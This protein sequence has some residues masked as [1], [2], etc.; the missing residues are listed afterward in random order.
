MTRTSSSLALSAAILSVSLLAAWQSEPADARQD[1]SI[2]LTLGASH[3]IPKTDLTVVFEAVVE[4]SRCPVG[5]NCVWAGNAVVQLRVDSRSAKP[6]S[7]RLHTNDRSAQ[8]VV[9][10][11]VRLRL[12]SLTPEP[13]ADGPPKTED[14]RLTLSIRI[15]REYALPH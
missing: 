8:E 15:E 2:V 6:A 10:R 12:S 11:D 5:T 14:Y 9:H 7:Y 13:T 3:R 1:E 4:D